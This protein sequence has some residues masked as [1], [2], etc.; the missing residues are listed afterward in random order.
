MPIV[1]SPAPMSAAGGASSTSFSSPTAMPRSFTPRSMTYSSISRLRSTSAVWYSIQ[2]ASM[3]LP[4]NGLRRRKRSGSTSHQLVDAL[5]SL[6]VS[7]EFF[8]HF[9]LFAFEVL[10]VGPACAVL[11]ALLFAEHELVAF[12]GDAVLAL[13]AAVANHFVLGFEFEHLVAHFF[14]LL[15]DRVNVRGVDVVSFGYL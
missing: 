8:L 3:S 10:L 4:Y 5:A 12:E 15:S 14:F 1:N 13:V 6:V 11:V 2:S 9:A 7:E